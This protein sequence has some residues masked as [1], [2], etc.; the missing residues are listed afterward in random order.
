MPATLCG[1]PCVRV[2]ARARRRWLVSCSGP[3]LIDSRSPR[4]AFDRHCSLTIRTYYGVDSYQMGRSE[5]DGGRRAGAERAELKGVWK[6][7]T[8]I[9]QHQ[10]TVHNTPCNPGDQLCVRSPAAWPCSPGPE[11]QALSLPTCDPTLNATPSRFLCCAHRPRGSVRPSRR[12]I[13]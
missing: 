5:K 2:C 3:A 9:S 7:A 12:A 8:R 13:S 1:P 4:S 11:N 10:Y 6:N